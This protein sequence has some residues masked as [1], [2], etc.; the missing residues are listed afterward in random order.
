MAEKKFKV[1]ICD[2]AILIRKIIKDI[3]K[4]QDC[5][6]VEAITADEAVMKYPQEK[7]DLI[8]M[9]VMFPGRNGIEA[10]MDIKKMNP[11]AHIIICTSII[12]QEQVITKSIEFG[13][14][15]YIAKPF[16][17]EQIIDVIEHYKNKINQKK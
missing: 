11:N 1:M 17:E 15:D 5:N 8:F 6:V 4:K 3:A 14:E 16:K 13:A 2:D 10:L 7:P 12:G 9:D